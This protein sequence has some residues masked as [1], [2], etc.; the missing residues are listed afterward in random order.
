M[1]LRED[2]ILPYPQLN[3]KVDKINPRGLEDSK[4]RKQLGQSSRQ[5]P[6]NRECFT[7]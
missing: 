5:L 2:F 7:L 4:E 1:S 6:W 3:A